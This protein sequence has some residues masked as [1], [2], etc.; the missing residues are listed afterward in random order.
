MKRFIQNAYRELKTTAIGLLL[1]ALGIFVALQDE[2]D[3]TLKTTLAIALVTAGIG[4]LAAKDRKGG[5][6]GPE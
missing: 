6:R 1:L 2:M 3:T 4:G 5:V